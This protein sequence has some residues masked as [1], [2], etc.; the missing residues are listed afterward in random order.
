M[1]AIELVCSACGAKLKCKSVVRV[2][3]IACP[4]CKAVVAIPD[5]DHSAMH[6]GTHQADVTRPSATPQAAGSSLKNVIGIVVGLLLGGIFVYADRQPKQNVP[7]A[8]TSGGRAGA[9]GMVVG[10]LGTQATFL[11]ADV[12]RKRKTT[13]KNKK[14]K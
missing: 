3:S 4:K 6:P 12:I 8:Y 7:A 5:A 2:K 13:P 14:A 9:A 10:Y 11:L 1:Q